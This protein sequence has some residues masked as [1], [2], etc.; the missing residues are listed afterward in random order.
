MGPVTCSQ[1]WRLMPPW[2]G[3]KSLAF[4]SKGEPTQG[5]PSAFLGLAAQKA[6]SW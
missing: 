2:L 6:R 4:H 3:L 5:V 1:T